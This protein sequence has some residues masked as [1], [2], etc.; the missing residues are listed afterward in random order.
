VTAT[1]TTF[2]DVKSKWKQARQGSRE[3]LL[4]VDDLNPPARKAAE[5]GVVLCT[6]KAAAVFD[7][8][9]GLQ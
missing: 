4:Q 8:H 1:A 7:I 5:E 2:E 9:I 6:C 3:L